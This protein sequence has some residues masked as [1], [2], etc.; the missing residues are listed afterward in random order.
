MLEEAGYE[1]FEAPDGR[2]ALDYLRTHPHGLGVLLD[3]HMP[4]MDGLAVLEAVS[5]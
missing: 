1:V 4:R 5:S 2:A 3:H